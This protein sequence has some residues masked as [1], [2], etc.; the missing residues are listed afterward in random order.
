MSD[1]FRKCYKLREIKGLNKFNTSKVTNMIGMFNECKELEYLD[2]SNFNTS[3]VTDMKCMFNECHK[4]KEIKGIERF[5]TKNVNVM[6]GLFQ[7][8][9]EIKYLDLSN[10]ITSMP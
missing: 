10:F 6:S 2:L 8:C 5:N 1:M 3:N 4:L 9:Y 7:E